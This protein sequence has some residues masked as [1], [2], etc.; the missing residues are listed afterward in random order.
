[1]FQSIVNSVK[2]F[3][4]RSW[5]IF[6]ARLEVLTGILVGAVGGLDW[7]ALMNLDFKD[8]ISSKNSLI[9]AGIIVVKGI[10][11]EIGRRAGTVVTSANQLVPANIAA[12]AGV[13]VK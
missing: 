10:V 6:I 12:K 11:S 4:I 3:F 9:I 1:M 5:S 8:A 7:T 2:A 13:A